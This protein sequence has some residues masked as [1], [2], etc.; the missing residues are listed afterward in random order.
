MMGYERSVTSLGC[1]RAQTSINARLGEPQMFYLGIDQHAKQLTISLRDET[2]SVRQAKQVSTEPVRIGKFLHELRE[3]CG[4]D[5]FYAIVEVCGFN[6]WLLELLTKHGCARVFLIQPE[7]KRKIKTDRRD[8]K[9]LSE[10]LW[11]NQERLRSGIPLNGVKQIVFP[12]A[13]DVE[14]QRITLIRQR[15]GRQNTRTINQIKHILRRH[16]LQWQLPTKTFP[17][18]IAITWLKNLTL[19]SWDR[20]EM[21]WLLEELKSISGRLAELECEIATRCINDPRVQLLKTTPGVADFSALAFACRI[22]DVTRFPSGRSLSNYWG[23]TPLVNDS[24]ESTGRRGRITK[25][26]STVAR[27][28]LGQVVLHVLRKDAKMKAW[29]KTI[30]VRRGSKIARVAVMRRLSVVIRNMLANNQDYWTCRM[31]MLERRA[32]QIQ[33]KNT[34]KPAA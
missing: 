3:T 32:K 22:G 5:G 26:G 21:N 12:S 6:D 8:A 2:G 10:L 15:I 27:W 29:Y 7:K 18:K 1:N 25:A 19:P 24:G 9:S 34:G 11:V 30:R 23:L 13:I 16:N 14:N 33:K 28:L 4:T 17:S 20:K 31:Q